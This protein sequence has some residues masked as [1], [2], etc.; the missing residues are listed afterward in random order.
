MSCHNQ[1]Q[2]AF[3]KAFQCICIFPTCLKSCEQCNINA[4][5]FKSWLQVFIVLSCKYG[6]RSNK[7]RLFAINDCL[8]HSPESNF[9]LAKSHIAN[10]KSVHNLAH[11]HISFYVG[12]CLQLVGS[13]FIWEGIFKFLLPYGVFTIS[14]PFLLLS[15]GV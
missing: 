4:K 13:F 14:K 15:F 11:F 10:K 8:K 9:G 12:D 5:F 3:F 1:V 7:H 2:S 6:C